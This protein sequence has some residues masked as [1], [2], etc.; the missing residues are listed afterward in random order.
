MRVLWPLLLI[1][2]GTTLFSYAV[3]LS[4]RLGAWTSRFRGSDAQLSAPAVPKTQMLS[5]RIMTAIL[6]VAGVYLIL[7]AV[8]GLIAATITR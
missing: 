2:F 7:A 1:A 6:R 5:I 4:E 8:I 3:P